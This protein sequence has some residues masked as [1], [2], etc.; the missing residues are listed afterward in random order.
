[1]ESEN[2]VNHEF[3]VLSDTKTH[4]CETPKWKDNGFHIDI[5]MESQNGKSNIPTIYATQYIVFALD[6]VTQKGLTFHY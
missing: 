3:S 2:Q 5:I 6:F 1:M 4:H